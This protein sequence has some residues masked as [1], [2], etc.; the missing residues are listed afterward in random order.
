[1]CLIKYVGKKELYWIKQFYEPQIKIFEVN[2]N[3]SHV[4][5]HMHHNADL[6]I[7]L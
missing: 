4:K 5:Q 7:Q 3:F 2:T 1:M 6:H